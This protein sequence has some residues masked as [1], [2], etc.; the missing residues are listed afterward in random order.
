[1]LASVTSHSWHG[2][3]KLS[4]ESYERGTG[5]KTTELA[6]MSFVVWVFFNSGQLEGQ[7]KVGH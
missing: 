1:M 2:L 5:L 6:V 4:Q 3:V 7:L